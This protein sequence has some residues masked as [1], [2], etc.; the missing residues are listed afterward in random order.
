MQFNK[1]ELILLFPKR[2]GKF[3]QTGES[4]AHFLWL[5]EG[6]LLFWAHWSLKHEIAIFAREVASSFLFLNIFCSTEETKEPTYS[7]LWPPDLITTVFLA[8]SQWLKWSVEYLVNIP[9][10]DYFTNLFSS[11]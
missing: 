7:H 10:K 4:A 3:V 1:C 6:L 5:D 8:N 2:P 9:L 11:Y